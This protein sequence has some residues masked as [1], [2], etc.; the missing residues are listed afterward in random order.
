MCKETSHANLTQ[1]EHFMR[2]TLKAEQYH[3]RKQRCRSIGQRVI[4]RL[5]LEEIEQAKQEA[6][7]ALLLADSSVT[8]ECISMLHSVEDDDPQ[9]AAAIAS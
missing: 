8:L 6:H 7:E 9:S 3:S 1:P 2:H 5:S 4:D